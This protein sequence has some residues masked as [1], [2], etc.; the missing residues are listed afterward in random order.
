[1]RL[2]FWALT[3]A[4]FC[5]IASADERLVRGY[6]QGLPVKEYRIEIAPKAME[7]ARKYEYTR[8]HMFEKIL[9]TC[10]EPCV[11]DTP[12]P[13]GAFEE[14]EWVAAALLAGFRKEVQ[15]L[16][17]CTSACTAMMDL[18]REHICIGRNTV[19][20]FHRGIEHDK[21]TRIVSAVLI[22]RYSKDIERWI[23]SRKGLP[24][25]GDFIH[26]EYWDAK[27]IWRTCKGEGWKSELPLNAP[28]TEFSHSLY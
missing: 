3:G 11:I 18:A 9:G 17:R 23:A 2:V 4:F 26:M 28:L 1:M 5:T 10:G 8:K 24:E 16:D 25:N 21:K 13:G 6:P 22:P 15:I 14:H 27:K 19:L 20:E 12:I 7:V